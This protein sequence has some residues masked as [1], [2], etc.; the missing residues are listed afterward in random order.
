MKAYQVTALSRAA[1]KDENDRRAGAAILK[2]V[3]SVSKELTS[4]DTFLVRDDNSSGQRGNKAGEKRDG[5]E[6]LHCQNESGM[7]RR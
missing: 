4:L 6:E 3:A 7:N 2:L 5:G 1:G